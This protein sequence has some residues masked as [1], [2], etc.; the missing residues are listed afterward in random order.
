MIEQSTTAQPAAELVL[1]ERPEVRRAPTLLDAHGRTYHGMLSL[2]IVDAPSQGDSAARLA[3]DVL[4][5]AEQHRAAAF[6]RSADRRCYTVAHV[7]LRVLLGAHL[8]ADAGAVR[9]VREPCPSCGDL[10]GRPAVQ[11]GGVHFSLSHSDDVVLIGIAE[12]PVG[13]DVQRIPPAGVVAETSASLH[14]TETA[15]LA[16]EPDGT[17]PLAFA[18][19]WTRKEAYLK[20]IGTGLSRDPALDYVGTGEGAGPGPRGWVLGD[21]AAPEGYAG[22]FAVRADGGGRRPC[23]LPRASG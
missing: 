10:H 7:A 20:G 19:A 14:P 9:L 17:K 15:E 16:A 23:P 3:P 21:V 11:G 6:R 22:A 5:G 18:R 4:D 13:V 8:G 12:A 1:G 2:W